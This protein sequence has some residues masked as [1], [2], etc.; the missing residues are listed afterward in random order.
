MVREGMAALPHGR[1]PERAMQ[2]TSYLYCT[3]QGVAP[4]DCDD[5]GPECATNLWALTEVMSL[6][7]VK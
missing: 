4:N 2:K 3:R 5:E 1:R 6:V 7:E